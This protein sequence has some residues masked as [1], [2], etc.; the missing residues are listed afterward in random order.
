M[1]GSNCGYDGDPLQAVARL[2]AFRDRVPEHAIEVAEGCWRYRRTNAPGVPLILLP[3][4]Q[5]TGDVFFDLATKLGEEVDCVTTTAPP[6]TDAAAMADSQALFMDALGINRTDLFGS[7]LGGYFAQVFALRHADRVR[8]IFLAN[9]FYDP[10][11]FLAAMPPA[12]QF[13]DMPA[14]TL[15]AQNMKTILDPPATEP[16]Q[17]AFQAVMRAQVG[18][19]QTASAYKSRFMAL[20]HAQGT[21]RIPMAIGDIVLIDDDRDPMIPAG[22][23]VAMRD[24]YAGAEHHMIA[25]GGHMPAIQRPGTVARI[26]RVRELRYTT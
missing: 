25:G 26:L 22:M 4:I 17:M 7:S 1:S 20:L 18:P 5:G 24:R 10:A 14:E 3:G 23:R 12:A 9:T 19:V 21:P 8:Q 2:E 13:A 16:G 11:L 6:I 15:V